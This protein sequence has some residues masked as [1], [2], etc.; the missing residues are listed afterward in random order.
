MTVVEN[1]SNAH[2]SFRASNLY[3]AQ[4][5]GRTNLKRAECCAWECIKNCMIQGTT[6]ANIHGFT[7]FNKSHI[8]T[9]TRLNVRALHTAAKGGRRVNGRGGGHVIVVMRNRSVT[10][11]NSLVKQFVPSH[12]VTFFQRRNGSRTGHCA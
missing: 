12:S 8:S 10:L 7:H 5:H 9:R 2:E 4:K 11:S 3:V 6:C 1:D